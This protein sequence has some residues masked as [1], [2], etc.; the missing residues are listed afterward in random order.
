M[1]TQTLQ[2]NALFQTGYLV[3]AMLENA[4]HHL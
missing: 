1:T 4:G 3:M 2:D